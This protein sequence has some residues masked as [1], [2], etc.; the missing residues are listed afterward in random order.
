M[1]SFFILS[2]IHLPVVSLVVF[3]ILV[4]AI[5]ILNGLPTPVCKLS[6]VLLVL[7]LAPCMS[8]NL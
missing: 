4:V 8:G 7:F 6:L 2:S 5:N 3:N 1:F